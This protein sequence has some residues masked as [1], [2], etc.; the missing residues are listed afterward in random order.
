MMV[1]DRDTHKVKKR[2]EKGGERRST[3]FLQSL[4]PVCANFHFFTIGRNQIHTSRDKS[5]SYNSLRQSAR[6]ALSKLRKEEKEADLFATF[7]N[8]KVVYI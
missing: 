1:G 3:D 4:F 2:Q 7:A 5:L 8:N 6:G